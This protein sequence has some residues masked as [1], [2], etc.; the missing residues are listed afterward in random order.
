MATN[1]TTLSK[2]SV[3]RNKWRSFKM[4]WVGKIAIPKPWRSRRVLLALLFLASS[5]VA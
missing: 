3:K 2:I 4:R 1:R 5:A